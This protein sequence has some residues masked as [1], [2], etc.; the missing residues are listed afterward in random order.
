MIRE[1]AFAKVNLFLEV[2]GKL[3]NGYH[4]LQ[5]VMVFADVGE[6][7]SVAPASSSQFDISGPQSHGLDAS[8]PGN[9]VL[10]AF[11]AFQQACGARDPYKIELHKTLPVSSGIGGGSADAAA[12]LRALNR[13]QKDPLP[14]HQLLK[15]A[16][17]LGSDVPACL[18]SEPVALNGAG[19]ELHPAAVA[20]CKHGILVNPGEAVST[21]AV[22]NALAA[23]ALSAIPVLPQAVWT[24][25]GLRQRRNDL[26]LPAAAICPAINDVLAFLHQLPGVLLAQMSG[27]GATCWAL[28]DTA[29]DAA[30]ASNAVLTARTD[31]WCTQV[32]FRH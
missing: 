5:S 21:P 26:R 27:S 3:P 24:L 22:F 14:F 31:W 10:K 25:E 7:V 15:I 1:P 23:P 11:S 19:K 17:T 13:L 16:A 12:V 9:L 30:S 18:G 2:A 28:F 8:A 29:S 32:R 20:G 4:H 6:W